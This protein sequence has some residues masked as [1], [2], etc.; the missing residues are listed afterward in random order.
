MV[1]KVITH[2]LD[3]N[4]VVTALNESHNTCRYIRRCA[5]RSHKKNTKSHRIKSM[6]MA[7]IPFVQHAQ[8]MYPV[9]IVRLEM[10]WR[11]TG[12]LPSSPCPPK[13][14]W[15]VPLINKDKGLIHDHV[16]I[17]LMANISLNNYRL[18]TSDDFSGAISALQRLQE[19]YKLPASSLA[20]GEVS[21]APS[22][23]KG[24]GGGAH[25]NTPNPLNYPLNTRGARLP[26]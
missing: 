20:S 2:G 17:E 24:G 1:A 18:P 22:M 15:Q 9:K 10:T 26:P 12:C 5:L 4:N 16:I 25:Q 7:K 23:S 6:Q 8:S 13:D 3:C 21:A 11:N 19:T 14:W